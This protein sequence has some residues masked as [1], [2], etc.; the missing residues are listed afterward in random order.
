MNYLMP[1]PL[2]HYLQKHLIPCQWGEF[3]QEKIND[4]ATTTLLRFKVTPKGFPKIRPLC[5]IIKQRPL[6][7]EPTTYSIGVRL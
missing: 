7:V 6:R 3:I 5:R 4:D 2:P 1:Y